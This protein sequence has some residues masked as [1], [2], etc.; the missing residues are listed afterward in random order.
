MSEP[1]QEHRVLSG[2]DAA[3]PARAFGGVIA[4]IVVV[5]AIVMGVA[6]ALWSMLN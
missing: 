5:V 3:A 1:E 4:V 6:Y 2:S